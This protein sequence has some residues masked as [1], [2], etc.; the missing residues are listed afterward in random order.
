M[1]R[2]HEQNVAIVKSL[3]S[4]AWSDEHFGNEEREMIDALLLAFDATEE[5]S[6]AI[7]E[8]A[9][10][11]RTLDD[12][13]LDELSTDDYRVLVQHAVLLTFIDGH[14]NPK[15]KEFVVELAKFLGIPDAEAAHLIEVAESRAKRN[16]KLL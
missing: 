5:Q 6:K 1:A 15:E 16:L 9:E 2:M 3:V 14:Q 7:K 4:V 10:T 11:R 8:Y 13:P 12:I